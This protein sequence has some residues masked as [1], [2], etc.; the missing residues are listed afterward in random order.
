DLLRDDV[1][2]VLPDPSQA[3]VGRKVKKLLSRYKIGDGTVWD[4]LQQN[5]TDNGHFTD[6]VNYTANDI[7]LGTNVDAGI[8]WDSTV[9]MPTFRDELTAIPVP[10]L[11]GDSSLVTLCVLNGSKQPTAAI[12]FA[13]FATARDK[14]LP[15]FKKFGTAPVE[16][17]VWAARPS[18]TFFCGAVNKRAMESIVEEFS[19]REDVEVKTVYDGCGIL[20][21][22]MGT[23]DDQS[24]DHGFPDVYMACDVYYLEN[25]KEWFEKLADVSENEIVIAVP[26]DSTRVT[27]LADIV[28]PG[29]R[30]AVGEP[31]ACTIGALTRRLLQSEGLWERFIQKKANK[32]EVVAEKSSS[33]HLIPDVAGGHV[34]AALAYLSDAKSSSD[35]IDIIRIDSKMKSAIQPLSLAVS[36]QHKHLVRRLYDRVADSREA[37]ENAGFQFRLTTKPAG[38]TADKTPAEIPSESNKQ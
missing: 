7:K 22:R 12:K 10:E 27:Q 28:K 16:G 9:A 15:V 33:A 24:T 30:V 31:D 13:R 32:D 6:T 37:F 3:A 5:I 38:K 25:V 29:I 36:S 34:D 8:V 21:S 4:K 23:I 19:L 20:T 35:Q 2:V 18:I 1:Q 17:D 11:E 14:G 26:K